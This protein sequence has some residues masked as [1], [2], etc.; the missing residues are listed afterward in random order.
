MTIVGTFPRLSLCGWKP[1]PSPGPRLLGN[2]IRSWAP[3]FG[4]W[5]RSWALPFGNWI[6]TWALLRTPAGHQSFA[7]QYHQS[8]YRC[9]GLNTCKWNMPSVRDKENSLCLSQ[10]SLSSPIGLSRIDTVPFSACQ[11]LSA[12][13]QFH[14]STKQFWNMHNNNKKTLCK[15]LWKF[16]SHQRSCNV[17]V[18]NT[19]T[20]CKTFTDLKTFHHNNKNMKE[21]A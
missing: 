14:N 16:S 10:L 7:N 6:R 2:W 9:C 12:A 13:T 5:I 21:E 8:T 17:A 3:P 15:Q 19:P 1:G 18:L 11:L 20:S 4:D